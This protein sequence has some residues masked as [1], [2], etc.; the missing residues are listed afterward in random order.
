MPGGAGCSRFPKAPTAPSGCF[1]TQGAARRGEGRGA[2]GEQGVRLRPRSIPANL[3]SVRCLWKAPCTAGMKNK[4]RNSKLN[5]LPYCIVKSKYVGFLQQPTDPANQAGDNKELWFTAV[6]RSV[7]KQ[8]EIGWAGACRGYPRTAWCP[9]SSASGR[10]EFSLRP[11]PVPAPQCNVWRCQEVTLT[12]TLAAQALP[13]GKRASASC[14]GTARGEALEEPPSERTRA[15]RGSAAP[16]RENPRSPPPPRVRRSSSQ[17]S[18]GLSSAGAPPAAGPARHL[19]PGLCRSLQSKRA[20]DWLLSAKGAILDRLTP[21]LT[22]LFNGSAAASPRP[23]PL[24][25]WGCP[26]PRG[27]RREVKVSREGNS[28]APVSPLR[29]PRT[30]LPCAHPFPRSRPHSALLFLPPLAGP[31]GPA[32]PPPRPAAHTPLARLLAPSLPEAPCQRAAAAPAR[33]AN[34]RGGDKYANAPPS[35]SPRVR[36]G[37]WGRGAERVKLRPQPGRPSRPACVVGGGGRRASHAAPPS[38]AP[39]PPPASPGLRH[40]DFSNFKIF[41][42]CQRTGSCSSKCTLS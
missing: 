29:L 41:H 13:R 16:V 10:R 30:L 24:P 32:P 20:R 27:L 5:S 42:N 2:R 4:E 26:L 25:A 35:P 11:L 36:W 15:R 6:S 34:Q 17:R 39:P 9:P 38:P 37:R 18:R 23:P 21:P 3:L 33:A 28:H 1:C 7:L 40:P 12:V 14:P 19:G 8:S 31:S 22:H